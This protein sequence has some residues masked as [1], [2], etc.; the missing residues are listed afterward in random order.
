MSWFFNQWFKEPGVPDL[1]ASFSIVHE[2]GKTYIAG[3]LKQRD[4]ARFKILA[5]PFVYTS[6]RIPAT[7]IVLMDKAEMSFKE[8]VASDA[9]DV[10]LDPAHSLLVYY[11]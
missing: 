4:R 11:H 9:S 10:S 8:E 3:H 6:K 2:G 7:R 5:L 1:E